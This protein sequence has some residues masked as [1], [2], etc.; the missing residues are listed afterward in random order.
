MRIRYPLLLACGLLAWLCLAGVTQQE[1]LEDDASS[2]SVD[3][4]LVEVPAA[5]FDGGRPLQ[6]LRREQFRVLEGRSQHEIVAFEAAEERLQ[7]ALL[8][9]ATG[10]MKDHLPALKEAALSF[11]GQLQTQDEVAIYTFGAGFRRE[12][13]FTADHRAASRA[14]LN[15]RAAGD[16]ALFDAIARAV[17]D[18]DRRKGKKALVV[19]TDGQDNR[20]A[21][22]AGS[23]SRRARLSGIPLYAIAQGEAARNKELQHTLEQI[24]RDTGGMFFRI[25]K[26]KELAGVFSEI[27]RNL[28]S[29]YMLAFKA[30]EDAQPGWRP[31]R[32]EVDAGKGVRIR[33]RQGYQLR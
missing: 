12:Q 3:V 14:L 24:A 4:S 16:T 20:S 6:R 17:R 29:T 15:L 1:G 26:P 19:F 5:V 21:L 33:A 13:A 22:N 7:C 28:S 25:S 32:V 8:L 9:D 2:F 31:I 27:T 18:L 30:P 10:S 11:V 23:A